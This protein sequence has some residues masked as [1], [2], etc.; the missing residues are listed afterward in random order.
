MEVRHP[1][2]PHALN[3][4]ELADWLRLNAVQKFTDKKRDHYTDEELQE[5][6]HESSLNGREYNRLAGIKKMVADLCSKGT[7]ENVTIVVPKTVGTKML[8]IQRRQNDDMVEFGFEETEVEVFAIPFADAETMEFFDVEGS[9]YADRSRPMSAK[10]RHEYI[11][12]FQ[13]L[14]PRNVSKPDANGNVADTDTG[15]IVDG[16][17]G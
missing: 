6:E 17:N 5:F 8:E 3:D 14:A 9:H 10:E 15:E 13:R 1:A 2:L 4:N 11:G 12:I 16:T 7:E